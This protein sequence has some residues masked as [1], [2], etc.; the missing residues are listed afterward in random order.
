VIGIIALLIS[1]LLPALGKARNQANLVACGSNMRQ[2]ALAFRMFSNDH[3]GTL[4]GG[5]FDNTLTPDWK[6]D[7]LFGQYQSAQFKMAPQEGT[8]F[9]YVNY[10]YKVYRC[11]ALPYTGVGAGGG[12]N[13]RFD[14]AFFQIFGGAKITNIRLT[15]SFHYIS[16][17]HQTPVVTPLITEENPLK[18]LNSGNIEGGHSNTDQLTHHHRGGCNYASIDGSVHFFDEPKDCD[19]WCWFSLA[20]SGKMV[21]LGDSTPHFGDWNKK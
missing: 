15:G 12:S 13:G 18:G 16:P 3:N 11:P 6:R 1:I 2:M 10:S 7:W 17:A 21:T 5:Y 4:P 8:I 20:P 19:S 9:P 14:M